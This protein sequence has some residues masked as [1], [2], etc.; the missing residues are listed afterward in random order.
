L[1]TKLVLPFAVY[2]RSGIKGFTKN[3]EMAAVLYLTESD[4]KKGE[5]HILKRSDEKLVFLAEG[6]YPIWLV[7]W[8]GATLL[9]DGLGIVEHMLLH[10]TLPDIGGFKKDMQSARTSEAHSAVLSQNADYFKGF[11]GE[12]KKTIEGLISSPRLHARL[13]SI[14][15]GSKG[16]RKTI[17]F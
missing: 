4:R 11:V 17:S 12:E 9:F 3:M 1:K 14:P 2:R 10:D 8:N 5:G 15:F 13:F 7:P 6:H 16:D